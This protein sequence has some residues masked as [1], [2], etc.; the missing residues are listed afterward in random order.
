MLQKHIIPVF[1]YVDLS[2]YDFLLSQK[3]KV[4][5]PVKDSSSRACHVY[6][7][8]VTI[9]EDFQIAAQKLYGYRLRTIDM[10][11]QD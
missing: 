1:M 4:D 2:D 10:A 6:E 8:V 9:P 11:V 7:V 5:L 3:S